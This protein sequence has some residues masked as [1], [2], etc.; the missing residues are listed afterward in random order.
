[1][2]PA[3]R[4]RIREFISG[5]EWATGH[6]LFVDQIHDL[7]PEFPDCLPDWDLGI[8]LGLDHIRRCPGWF[9]DIR[10]LI[11]HLSGLRAE[12]GRIFVLFLAYRSRPWLQEHLVSVDNETVDFRRLQEAIERLV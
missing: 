4:S 8:N 3:L 7:D 11:E 2:A 5:R 9:A 10:A 12:T 6:V 1:V